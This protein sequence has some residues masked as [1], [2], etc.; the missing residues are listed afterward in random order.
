[1]LSE[2]VEAV[3]LA[4]QDGA[5]AIPVI[6]KHLDK[7]LIVCQGIFSWENLV[8]L[9]RADMYDRSTHG[10]INCQSFVLLSIQGE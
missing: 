9:H 2:R 7:G 3:A 5:V 8:L 6:L 1:M 4:G 10:R